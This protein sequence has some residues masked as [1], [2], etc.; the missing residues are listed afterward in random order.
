MAYFVLETARYD[1]NSAL[2]SVPAGFPGSLRECAGSQ[3]RHHWGKDDKK[4]RAELW[5]AKTFI[6]AHPDLTQLVATAYVRAQYWESQEQ[7]RPAVIAT[8]TLT[9]GPGTPSSRNSITMGSVEGFLHT[10][11][12]RRGV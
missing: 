8:T 9:G 3:D 10:D 1:Q 2:D 6:D 12:R 7:N 11:S 4:I 5:A